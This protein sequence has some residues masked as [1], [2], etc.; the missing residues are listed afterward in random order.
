MGKKTKTP[1]AP[2]QE[3]VANAPRHDDAEDPQEHVIE[4]DTPLGWARKVAEEDAAGL[5]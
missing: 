4:D 2:L 1:G 5:D 3:E